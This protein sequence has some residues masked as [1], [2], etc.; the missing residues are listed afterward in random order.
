MTWTRCSRLH[1]KKAPRSVA[2]SIPG[3]GSITRGRLPSY[4][5]GSCTQPV[6]WRM[7]FDCSWQ[8]GWSNHH[9]SSSGCC[10]IIVV[11]LLAQPTFHRWETMVCRA[12]WKLNVMC[13]VTQ[14]S[15]DDEGYVLC[16][17]GPP[18]L[19]LPT[20]SAK[21]KWNYFEKLILSHCTIKP[22]VL[23]SILHRWGTI[24]NFWD[25]TTWYFFPL[26]YHSQ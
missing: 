9:Q 3:S 19:S 23:R 15:I 4:P 22:N 24:E 13:T 14:A 18:P 8:T 20:A 16:V 6:A 1:P 10:W 26:G 5:T 12:K 2:A 21:L 17:I 11:K 25:T 7:P